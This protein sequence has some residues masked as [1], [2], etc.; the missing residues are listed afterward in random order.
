MKVEC[1]NFGGA[2]VRACAQGCGFVPKYLLWK[3]VNLSKF[4]VACS[5]CW[6]RRKIEFAALPSR[7]VLC[8]FAY[9]V[10]IEKVYVNNC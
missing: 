2:R 5:T 1:T 10:R 3:I 7:T 6:A 4:W 9:I 8:A